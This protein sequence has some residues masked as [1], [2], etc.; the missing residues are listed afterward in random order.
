MKRK[1]AAV[2]AITAT[3][4]TQARTPGKLRKCCSSAAMAMRTLAGWAS[5][6]GVT[7]HMS[8]PGKQAHQPARVYRRKSA[9]R[10]DNGDWKMGDPLGQIL[11]EGK[12]ATVQE[13]AEAPG[14]EGKTLIWTKV[15]SNS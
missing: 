8:K 14:L 6:C 4:L 15:S 12:S 11:Q 13:I 5:R 2:T 10:R 7:A 3:K 1:K 9:P